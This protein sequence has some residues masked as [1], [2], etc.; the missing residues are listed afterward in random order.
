MNN[1]ATSISADHTKPEDFG[2]EECW[3]R[4]DN[5]MEAQSKAIRVVGRLQSSNKLEVIFVNLCFLRALATLPFF[6][7][8]AGHELMRLTLR[9][10]YISDTYFPW[11]RHIDATTTAMRTAAGHT[12]TPLL[13]HPKHVS[14][15]S[16]YC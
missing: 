16:R 3:A 9:E 6:R 15:G 11:K 13:I 4:G 2:E 5:S 7:L 12:P 1:N 10:A 14:L 8:A